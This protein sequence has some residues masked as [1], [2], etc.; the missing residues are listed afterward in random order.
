M[1]NLAQF[2]MLCRSR[3]RYTLFEINLLSL[4]VADFVS[5]ICFV[6]F[7]S[8]GIYDLKKSIAI[9][10][11]YFDNLNAGWFEKLSPVLFRTTLMLSFTHI[12]FIAFQRFFS[13]IFPFRFRILFTRKKCTSCIV[14][15]WITSIG[16]GTLRIFDERITNLTFVYTNLLCDTLLVTLYS[17]LCYILTRRSR[18]T[19]VN[20][21]DSNNVKDTVR[22]VF[23]YSLCVTLAF[24]ATTL[25]FTV[26]FIVKPTIVLYT[27]SEALLPLNAV[28]NTL[29]YFLHGRFKTRGHAA[30]TH[31]FEQSLEDKHL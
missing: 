10:M 28:L 5:S 27:I 4:C 31:T 30:R 2:I 21:T 24:I 20:T 1:L 7:G 29:V 12:L 16:Y 19:A 18:T 11:S 22:K 13:S 26:C 14:L 25:P 9:G 23:L 3:T 6:G 15:L 8:L 17:A